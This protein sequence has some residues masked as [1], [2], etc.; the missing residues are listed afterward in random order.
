VDDLD[1]VCS[2]GGWRVPAGRRAAWDWLPPGGATA[3]P[4][5]VP[6]WLRVMYRMPLV[7]RYASELMWFRGG[8]DVAP[9]EDLEPGATAGLVRSIPAPRRRWRTTVRR[10]WR[11]VTLVV[12]LFDPAERHLRRRPPRRGFRGPRRWIL[13]WRLR[14]NWTAGV[15]PV[16]DEQSMKDVAKRMQARHDAAI[17]AA[18][19]SWG[20]QIE[21]AAGELIRNGVTVLSLDGGQVRGRILRFWRGDSVLDLE[22]VGSGGERGA[23]SKI[24]LTRQQETDP[25]VLTFYLLQ[26]AAELSSTE[27]FEF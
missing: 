13:R 1:S 7:D 14:R 12:G 18:R 22:S 4:D 8:W 23:T 26:Q 6:V 17:E 15:G 11:L 3:R 19:R 24:R 9:P 25:E 21:R 10:E 5:R 2:P 20:P 27:G 16:P